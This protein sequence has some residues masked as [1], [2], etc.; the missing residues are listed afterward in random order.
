MKKT[1]QILFVIAC[2][3][4]GPFLIYFGWKQFATSRELQKSGK[5]A[6]GKV[7]DADDVRGRRGRHTYYLT[8]DFQAEG[9]RAMHERIKVDRDLFQAAANKPE[10]KITYLAEDPSTCVAGEKV[11]SKWGMMAGGGIA[12]VLGVLGI[13]TLRSSSEDTL[14]TDD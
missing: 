7:V 9:G 6:V 1:K 10:V 14:I 13:L 5:T 4:I 2:L 12:L 11:E 8:V 3:I